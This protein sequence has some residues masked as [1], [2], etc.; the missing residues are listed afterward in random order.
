[1]AQCTTIFR[2]GFSTGKDIQKKG[3]N[4]APRP[5]FLGWPFADWLPSAGDI[6]IK[7]RRLRKVTDSVLQKYTPLCLQN[8]YQGVPAYEI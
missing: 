7:L 6:T 8:A 5:S 1:V 3:N 2:P 4:V